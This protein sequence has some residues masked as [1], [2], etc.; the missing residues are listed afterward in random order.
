[1]LMARVWV[2]TSLSD[3]AWRFLGF[4]VEDEETDSILAFF[5]E[6]SSSPFSIVP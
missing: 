4:F 6:S 2:F 1:M 3:C 5:G